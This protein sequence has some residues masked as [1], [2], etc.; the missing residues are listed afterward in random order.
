MYW[1]V[2]D[3]RSMPGANAWMGSGMATGT[4]R[5]TTTTTTKGTHT[6]TRAA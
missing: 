3:H 5:T 1:K 2:E 4:L 6:G